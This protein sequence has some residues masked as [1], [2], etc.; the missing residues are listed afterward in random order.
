MLSHTGI[1]ERH[2]TGNHNVYV[3]DLYDQ[4]KKIKCPESKCDTE[5]LL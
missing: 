5:N 1:P 3:K 2:T 4:K